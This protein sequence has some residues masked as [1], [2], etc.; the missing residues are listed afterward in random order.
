[1]TFELVDVGYSL[2]FGQLI[3]FAPCNNVY[4]SFLNKEAFITQQIFKE[5]SSPQKIDIQEWK[6]ECNN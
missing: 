3:F 6:L 1:M 5:G 4:F 2:P